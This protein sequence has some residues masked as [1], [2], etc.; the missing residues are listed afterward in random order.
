MTPPDRIAG[1]PITWGVCE[2][3]GWGHQMAP[4]RVLAEMR[5]LGLG[6]TELGPEGFLPSEGARELLTAFGLRVVAGFV[7]AVLYEESR[8]D[9]ELAAISVA[10][11]AIATL[12]GEVVVLA[13]ST[14]SEGY[15]GRP[16]LDAAAWSELARGLDRVRDLA[17]RRGLV[18]AVHPHHGTVVER[19]EDVDLLLQLTDVGLCLDTGHLMVGGGDPA[20]LA[21]AASARVVHVHLKDVDA[22]LASRVASGDLGY[23]EAVRSGLYRP[24]GDG[25]VDIQAVIRTLESSG[26]AGWYVLEHDEVLDREPAPGAGPIEGARRSLAFLDRVWEEVGSTTGR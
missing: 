9:G 15:E 23:H 12:G 22:A 14:G 2:V 11:D 17:S 1:A 4:E 8:L 19:P 5:S 18:V 7:P 13:A 25:D 20:A 10:V 24:L 26:Y 3:P 16:E 6:A 21:G